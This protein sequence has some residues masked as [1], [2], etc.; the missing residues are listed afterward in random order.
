MKLL[1]YLAPIA[2]MISNS[3]FAGGSLGLSINNEVAGLEY[4]A[5]RM[6]TPLHVS[7]GF[8]HH[9]D[10]GNVFNLGINAVDVRTQGS[11]VRI[12][13]GG[14][15][16]GYFTDYNDSGA[17]AIGGF[18]DYSPV[19]LNGLALGG[20]VYYSPSVLSFEDTENLVDLGLEV[21]Y[22]LLPTAKIY[23]GYRFIEAQEE[24]VDIE[25]IKAGVV[26][27]QIDF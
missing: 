13:I 18:V 7:A 17:I 22:R 26:G 14:K 10:D 16:Y 27:L 6:G 12:G 1:R 3:A 8:I 23:A 11:P 19:Q 5:T 21:G 9:E 20:H 2:L 25:V 24:V 15:L 4:D